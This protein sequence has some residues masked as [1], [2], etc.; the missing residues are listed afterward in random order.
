LGKG[1]ATFGRLQNMIRHATSKEHQEAEAAWK[2]RVFSEAATAVDSPIQKTFS[3]IGV[4][5]I[6]FCKIK[7]EYFCHI[8]QKAERQKHKHEELGRRYH[9]KFSIGNI[10]GHINGCCLRT[11]EIFGILVQVL[12]PK[13]AR[14]D[15]KTYFPRPFPK[16]I[17][18]KVSS[19]VKDD[20]WNDEAG[21]L[22]IPTTLAKRDRKRKQKR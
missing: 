17:F 8:V 6:V 12:K 3:T 14:S 18:A 2:E 20:K 22:C 16:Y 5:D 10:Q 7:E 9:T 19:L 13:T 11:D 15:E 21:K 4:G 1:K